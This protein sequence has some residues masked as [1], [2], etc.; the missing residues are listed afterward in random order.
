MYSWCFDIHA[1]T[2]THENGFVLN[3][4]TILKFCMCTN[5]RNMPTLSHNQI[6]PTC[7]FYSWNCIKGENIHRLGCFKASEPFIAAASFAIN[8]YN[9]KLEY[10]LPW[11]SLLKK[12]KIITSER[13][14]KIQTTSSIEKRVCINDWTEKWNQRG[15]SGTSKSHDLLYKSCIRL[16]QKL[17]LVNS[18]FPYPE[19]T[20]S[21]INSRWVHVNFHPCI[22]PTNTS[23]DYSYL[24]VFPVNVL[25][26]FDVIYCTTFR[27][28]TFIKFNIFKIW[29]GLSSITKV[30]LV[31]NCL[32]K[33]LICGCTAGWAVTISFTSMTW[34]EPISKQERL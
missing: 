18:R 16:T 13:L 7:I 26:L 4:H 22:F 20:F 29:Q 25:Q 2:F 30:L 21:F 14:R 15:W 23:H 34:L 10:T 12:Q 3:T 11:Y 5:E 28:S 27:E 33:S 9:Q 19:V 32:G 1:C 17:F 24:T 31:M 6:H 8:S